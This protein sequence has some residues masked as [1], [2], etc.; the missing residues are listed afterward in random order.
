[1]G[2]DRIYLVLEELNLF[3]DFTSESKKI[4]FTN[5]GEKEALAAMKVVQKLRNQ[6][7]YAELY[8]EAAK[9]KKQFSYADKGAFTHVAIIGTEE[10]NEGKLSLK[11]LKTG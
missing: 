6:G 11:D 8:P 3:P 2:L 4:L 1:F 10:M 9:M 7:I 5:F